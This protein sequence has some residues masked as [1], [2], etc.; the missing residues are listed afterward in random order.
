MGADTAFMLEYLQCRRPE[1]VRRPF[2]AKFDP[3]A[4]WF[5]Q[6]QPYDNSDAEMFPQYW[7][8]SDTV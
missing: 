7:P 5:D 2:F 6:L 4:T 3:K 8:D 1:L